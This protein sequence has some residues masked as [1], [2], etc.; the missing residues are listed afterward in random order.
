MAVAHCRAHCR[1]RGS[2]HGADE[3]FGRVH[4][5]AG[6]APD[7]QGV[8]ARV[9]DAVHR[10]RPVRS[11]RQARDCHVHRDGRGRRKAV[12]LKVRQAQHHGAIRC[13]PRRREVHRLNARARSLWASGCIPRVCAACRG[14]KRSVAVLAEQ[15]H[16]A[17]ARLVHIVH[18]RQAKA[19]ME[20]RAGEALLLK[21]VRKRPERKA[22]DVG[23]QPLRRERDVPQKSAGVNPVAVVP[24]ALKA[25]VELGEREVQAAARGRLG[26]LGDLLDPAEP[27]SLVHDGVGRV[28]V[29]GDQV[30]G[31]VA[32]VDS[33]RQEL[34][35]PA[36]LGSHRAR[37]AEGGVC[38]PDG[39]RRVLVQLEVCRLVAAVLAA[40]VPDVESAVGLVERLHNERGLVALPH[41]GHELL[42]K[43]V[44]LAPVLWGLV[45]A[46]VVHDCGRNLVLWGGHQAARHER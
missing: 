14:P 37:G 9:V 22:L 7:G 11:G 25:R 2:T 35:D 1:V 12:G 34:L 20:R 17:P 5:A 46:A 45:N 19:A 28:E 15:L 39:L 33:P 6:L 21:H 3:G 40:P 26:C 16:H 24:V 23:G 13:P 32:L 8:A 4:R 10:G 44:P 36:Q 38:A 27:I 18:R 42:D 31:S 43:R 41:V 30:N 29:R